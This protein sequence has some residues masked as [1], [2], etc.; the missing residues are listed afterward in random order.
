MRTRRAAAAAIAALAVVSIAVVSFL[1][2]QRPQRVVHVE[3][4]R[5]V[6][7]VAAANPG[8]ILELGRGRHGPFVLDR[9]VEVRAADGATVTGPITV[10]ADGVVI[11]DLLIAGGAR[12]GILVDGVDGVVIRDVA[13]TDV[14]LHGIEVVDATAHIT[15][16]AVSGLGEQGQGI[17][18]RNAAGRG[19]TVVR[20]CTITGGIEGLV[21]HVS[22]VEFLGN[23][24]TGT[25]L[26]AIAIME[27]SEALIEGNT[28]ADATG[29]AIFCGDMSHCEVRGNT[30]I[31]I[32]DDGS[33][34]RSHS[35]WGAVVWYYS[36]M[37]LRD[38]AFDVAAPESILVA[39]DSTLTD[40]FPLGVWPRGWRG[41]LPAVPI[42]LT[43]IAG[44]AL[45][46]MLVVPILRRAPTR[47]VVERERP[48]AAAALLGGFLVQT[49][50]MVEHGVQL[51]QIHAADAEIRAGLLGQ[52]FN[53]EWLHWFFNV[54]I[55]ALL[56]LF[57]RHA[58]ASGGSFR[59]A[60]KGAAWLAAAG[61]AQSYHVLEHSAKLTQHLVTDVRTAPGIIGDDLGLVWFH[62]AINLAVYV[63][64]AVAAWEFGRPDPRLVGARERLLGTTRPQ[65]T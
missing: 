45:V 49:F 46:R 26:R 42:G 40:R 50:H 21:S 60:G 34:I 1:L 2:A 13:I 55:L 65:T 4:G 33:G 54:G 7:A 56:V 28:V 31:A 59:R 32:R 6:G 62:Y 44:L 63:G 57:W 29:A 51:W 3:A 11:R 15:D 20:G 22:R 12:T 53:T 25:S 18:V 58:R 47:P 52:D 19:H 64:T 17:E 24:V 10:L 37:R 36:S 30:A 9:Q 23:T 8:A 27:M 41:L 35:G 39:D 5:D 14:P 61:I 16:C 38:N 43:A 48:L